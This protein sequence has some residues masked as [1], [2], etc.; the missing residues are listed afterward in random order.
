MGKKMNSGEIESSI[1]SKIE[2]Y[3]ASLDE[4]IDKIGISYV[5]DEESIEALK[6]TY[7]QL[8]KMDQQECT[9]L[10][11]K[12]AQYGLYIQS[13]QNRLSNINNW[14]NTALEKI[15]GKHAQNYGTQFTKYEEKK[16]CIIA[17]NSAAAALSKLILKSSGKYKE[18]NGI[19]TKIANMSTI[20]IELSKSKRHVN[21]G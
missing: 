14:C 12:L 15:V 18:L 4:L 9:I 8:S 5:K 21:H 10:A 1:E 19:S 13:V 3:E 17:E 7:N 6:L 20:L 16:A 11:Y 2:Q